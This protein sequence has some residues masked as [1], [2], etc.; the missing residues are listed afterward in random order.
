MSNETKEYLGY[1]ELIQTMNG[2]VER[3]E[4]TQAEYDVAAKAIGAVQVKTAYEIFKAV[5]RD[6]LFEDA[7]SQ[8]KDYFDGRDISRQNRHYNADTLPIDYNHLVSEFSDRQDC[9]IAENDLWQ[10]IIADYVK[11]LITKA[12]AE[13]DKSFGAINKAREMASQ[14]RISGPAR[15]LLIDEQL[16]QMSRVDAAKKAQAEGN[17]KAF[18]MARKAY[19]YV[20]ANK[21]QKNA[22]WDG[23]AKGCYETYASLANN[24]S[25]KTGDELAEYIK[26]RV[27][28]FK[29]QS[30]V[31]QKSDYNQGFVVGCFDAWTEVYKLAGGL[32]KAG[33]DTAKELGRGQEPL[34]RA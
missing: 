1:N 23:Y 11:E 22:Y 34:G 20:E 18:V 17:L 31:P 2:M 4:M 30:S 14:G 29:E 28:Y 12:E 24:D 33:L 32:E 5:D 26:D 21:P 7:R 15:D 25:G 9:N 3:G 8:V 10:S 13:Y 19:F 16:E 6:Y 27:E